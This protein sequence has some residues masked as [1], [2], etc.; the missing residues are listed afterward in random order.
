[1]IK[2][3]VKERLPWIGLFLVQ[4]LL[5]LFIAFIDPTVPFSSVLYISALSALLFLLFFAVRCRK[6]TAFYKQLQALDDSLDAPSLPRPETPFEHIAAAHV[7]S[8]TARYRQK[9]TENQLALEQEKDD[10]LSW[11]HEVKT[12]MTAMHLMLDRLED[13]KAKEQL[14]FEWLRIHLLLD[15]QL[16]R[17]RLP[18]IEND[19]YIEQAALEPIV[20]GEIRSLQSW[21]FQKGI[22]FDVD[23]HALHV[24]SDTKWLSFI[25]RQLL[26]NAVKYSETGEI[27]IRSVEQDGRVLLQVTDFGRGI[28]AQDLPRIFEKGFTSTDSVHHQQ[29]GA[30]GMGLYLAAKAAST[31]LIQIKAESVF[32]ERTTFTL[33]FPK[34]N[35]L[36]RLPG[37]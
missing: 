10:L 24:L 28:S 11:V 1:M 5:I 2:A 6:E 35:E 37:M 17:K 36:G 22:G 9:L 21:C 32:E 31:L 13:E 27:V 29:N 25:L 19:L 14:T 18:F 3:F 7:E 16:H 8:Q 20:F 4:Q 33:T 26:T 12:P 30:T 23:L 15:Q 34:Q